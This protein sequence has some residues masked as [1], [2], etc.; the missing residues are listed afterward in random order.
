MDEFGEK[1]KFY[2]AV[3]PCEEQHHCRDCEN[4]PG[5]PENCKFWDCYAGYECHFKEK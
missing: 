1:G 5:C 2:D 3:C 4:N